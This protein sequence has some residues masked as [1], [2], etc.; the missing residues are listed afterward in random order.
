[1]PLKTWIKRPDQGLEEIQ[2]SRNELCL[3]NT[4]SL[5]CTARKFVVVELNMT[6]HHKF[7]IGSSCTFCVIVL[8]FLLVVS[9]TRTLP[10]TEINYLRDLQI[11]WKDQ[12]ILPVTKVLR[13]SR[14]TSFRL[15]YGRMDHY[16]LARSRNLFQAPHP[17]QESLGCIN[18][19]T[20]RFRGICAKACY[21]CAGR[22]CRRVPERRRKPTRGCTNNGFLGYKSSPACCFYWHCLRFWKSSGPQRVWWRCIKSKLLENRCLSNRS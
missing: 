1:M 7:N 21:E 17:D 2:F 19:E 15:C 9:G 8:K 6:L 12:N 13:L 16:G 18:I 3:Y 5:T 4:T 10:E 20:T 11:G 14:T 22:R